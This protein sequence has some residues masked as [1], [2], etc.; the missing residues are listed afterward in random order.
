V[1]GLYET[2]KRQLQVGDSL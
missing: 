1:M 2:R